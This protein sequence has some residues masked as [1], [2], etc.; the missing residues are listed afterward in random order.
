[1]R[2]PA[3]LFA[4]LPLLAAPAP[5]PPHL[6]IPRLAQPPSMLRDAD[7]STW[8]G[9]L[10]ITDFGMIMPTDTGE[11]RWP[12]TVHVGWG[13]DALYVAIE[14]VDPDPA[15]IHAARHMR[16]TNQGD[17]DFVGVDLDPSG[18]GQTITRFFVTPLGGQ[19]DEIASDSTGENA[20]YD[21][22]WDSTGVLTPNGYVVKMRIPY[23][24]LRR[25]PGEWAL[26]FLRI[27]PRERRYGISWPRMSKDVQ[28]DICQMARV[29]GAPVD[30]PG[31]PF[32]LIPFATFNR[33]QTLDPDPAAS[34]RSQ[35]RLGMD[36]R[37]ATTSLTLEGSYRPDFATA[38][39]D[40]DPLQINSRFKVFYP[41]RRPFFLEG[42][43]LLG[44]QG[45]Q[46]QFFSR[47]IQDPLYGV[48]ASGQADLAS[49]TLLHAKDQDGGLLLS[50]NGAMGVDALPTRDTA[51]AV[52]FRT[53]E[54]GSGISLLGTDKTLMGGPTGVGGQSG[55]LYVDQYLGSE[56]HFI[57]SGVTGTAHLPMEDGSLSSNRGTA[58]YAE[59]DWS[60]RH[61]WAWASTQATS[62]DLVLLSGFTDLQGYRR[63]NA[64]FGWRGNWNE[65][66]L[67]F[68]NASLR[69]RQLT[70]WNSDPMDRAVGLDAW[71]ETKGRLSFFLN[72]DAAGRTWGE[73]HDRSVA[74]RSLTLG[75]NWQRH[76]AFR[77]GW[78]ATQARTLEL[79]TG[80]P[81]R[82]RSAALYLYGT[83]GSVSY[84]LTGQQS[85]LDREE[86]HLRLI[87][88]REL[89][90]SGSWQF[91]WFFYAKTQ[92]FV[93]RY[94]G[95]EAD[96]VDKFLKL[97]LGWQPNAFTNAYL[98]WS[99]QRRRDP[100][101]VITTERMVERGLFA[102]LAYAMQF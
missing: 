48:K 94:D 26:R 33:T 63:Q 99:G 10:V 40:V 81:A 6:A 72:W 49:W 28:C 46:R 56:F 13:P 14:A 67:N 75:G 70:W 45:A 35:T 38:D 83:I 53:D 77:L 71:L 29:S 73:A 21:C 97:F 47:S 41:E 20:S 79:A 61:W 39:A 44:V 90:A 34:A 5:N 89:T 36:L 92:A 74:A 82:F 9:A 37:Y 65:G 76:S 78:Y 57:G 23:S 4:C 85:G 15:K 51:A 100:M 87:R 80:D 22:L 11:N 30:K 43:D 91:P 69:W 2:H 16:D 1:M 12:T 84:N 52:K 24:S 18:K 64:G 3:L 42:M 68:A 66:F 101:A 7:L 55:G 32:L 98:G 88:A 93:V 25:M 31:S 95:T 54:R 17:F 50:A 62:P 102:K 58:T 8:T 60:T 27:I 59:L 19:I 86:D 96:G